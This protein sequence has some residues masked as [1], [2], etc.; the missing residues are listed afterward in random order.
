MS[1]CRCL[2]YPLSPNRRAHPRPGAV[3]GD[4]GAPGQ[5]WGRAVGPG[6]NEKPLPIC[7]DC[8]GRAVRRGRAGAGRGQQRHRKRGRAG[9]SGTARKCHPPENGSHAQGFRSSPAFWPDSG[10]SRKTRGNRPWPVADLPAGPPSW[11]GPT[12]PQYR[13]QASSPTA[14]TGSNRST[15]PVEGVREWSCARS[16]ANT[17]TATPFPPATLA[18][19]PQPK[20][21]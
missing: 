17:T 15:R 18:L 19:R 11:Y 20:R 3:R 14:G 4:Q 9:L 16:A 5:T 13:T 10:S 7:P 6:P 21:S 8:R 12:R 2:S 1:R